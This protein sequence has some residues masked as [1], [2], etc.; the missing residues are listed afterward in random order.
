[1]SGP[2][3][4]L[5]RRVA[6]VRRDGYAAAA[7]LIVGNRGSTPQSAGALMFVDELGRLF[8]TI[9]GGCIEADVR[10][11]ALP[12]IE[13]KQSA[14]LKFQL[15]GDYGW[16]DGL[17][18]GGTIEVA[19][20]PAPSPEVLEAIA[21]AI[22]QRRATRLDLDVRGVESPER[23]T[24]HIPSRPRLYIAGAGHIGQATARLAMALDFDVTIFD[25]RADL[26]ARFDEPLRTVSGPIAQRLSEAEIDRSTYCLIVTRGHRH[27]AQALA[28]V[29]EREAPGDEPP[30][31]GMIGSRRK[32]AV[33]FEELESRGVARERLNSVCAPVGLSIGS[34]TVEEIAISIAAQLVQVRAEGHVKEG[35]RRRDLIERVATASA[36][37]PVGRAPIGVLLA[38]GR[39]RRMG[40][41]KQTLPLPDDPQQRTLAAAAFD[42]I[43]PVCS[44]MVVV[45]AHEALA[46]RAALGERPFVAATSPPDAEMFE[47]IL[48]GLREAIRIDP[49]ASVLLHLADH[50]RVNDA[51]LAAILSASQSHPD[52]A[53]MPTFNEKGGHPV[54]I[55]ASLGSEIIALGTAGAAGGLRAFWA[56]NPQR[57][58]RLAVEDA[59][60]VLDID[61]PQDY[62]DRLQG[63]I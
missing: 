59:T 26:L 62:R 63:A 24:L 56:A 11:R 2:P 6:A 16:D 61:S 23:I 46:V 33:T 35:V 8:G 48:A 45:V 34:Q 31:I 43:A 29:L 42:A 28:A 14:I 27:D 60:V 12:M 9:G 40:R 47:S 3:P 58:L 37:R 51:A 17:I 18:C 50:P 7:C 39:S 13:R 30:Y 10:R 15:D 25:D 57:C 54:F 36:M 22:E 4:D 21:A 32:V 19:V 5:L 20:A 41:T 49:T 38:A 1:M 44:Q 52:R 53:I 55:P